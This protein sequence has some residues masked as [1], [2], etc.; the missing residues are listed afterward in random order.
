M[1]EDTWY[2]EVSQGKF[3]NT[4]AQ[5]LLDK[6]NEGRAI[7]GNEKFAG[8]PSYQLFDELVDSLWYLLY[9]ESQERRRV[10]LLEQALPYVLNDG[11]VSGGPGFDK[12]LGREIEAELYDHYER[13]N[14]RNIMFPLR[15]EN[16]SRQ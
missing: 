3:A 5:H 1:N 12:E 13:V 15:E 8:K 10:H 14:S 9:M 11:W 4:T 7:Y 2:V 16:W 6:F